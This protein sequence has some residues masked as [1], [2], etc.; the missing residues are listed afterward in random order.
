MRLSIIYIYVDIMLISRVYQFEIYN[1]YMIHVQS[2]VAID[3]CQSKPCSTHDMACVLTSAVSEMMVITARSVN[4]VYMPC[5][6]YQLFTLLS[7]YVTK[8]K[9]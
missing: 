1:Q 8:Y 2:V 9:V 4:T 6:C 7:S 5:N 3:A